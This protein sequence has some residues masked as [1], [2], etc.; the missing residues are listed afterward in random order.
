MLVSD[1]GN[2]FKQD[3]SNGFIR[4]AESKRVNI[5]S[6]LKET[7]FGNSKSSLASRLIHGS[8]WS[9][10]GAVVFRGST[11]ASSVVIARVLGKE[12]FGK[13]GIIQSTVNMFMVFACAG[14]GLTSTKF[15]SQ[16]RRKDPRTAGAVIGVS[17]IFSVIGGSICT[18]ALFVFSAPIAARFLAAP[19]LANILRIASPGLLFGAL[20]AVQIGSLM[21]FEAFR[22]IARISLIAGCASF[23]LVVGGVYTYG[24]RGAVAGTI[25]S[26]AIM[27]GCSQ[28][29]LRRLCRQ[30]GVA[31][32]LSE[33]RKQAAVVWRFTIPAALAAS[34]VGPV[35]WICSAALVNQRNGY[36]E[37]GLFNAANQW[38]AVLLFLPTILGQAALPSLSESFADRNDA[39]LSKLL[40][41]CVK[42]NLAFI[43]PVVV[44][45]SLFS[46]L[47]M[48][49]YGPAF[50][51]GWPVLVLSF[52]TAGILA[53]Q[54]PIGD[55][56]VASGMMWKGFGLN[57]IWAVLF[58]F[59]TLSAIRWGAAGLA[60]ARLFAYTLHSVGVI[61]I[62]KYIL[63][64]RSGP[65]PE[66]ATA[67]PQAN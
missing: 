55:L 10:V 60:G 54:S 19:D 58:I 38:F 44:L 52:V 9:L 16:F 45:G 49:L 17:L 67:G 66:F 30:E 29:V 11:L 41:I 40:M 37:M 33:C 24:L 48:R 32:L 56:I 1:A 42:A 14:V 21:G 62:A 61:W 22:S 65:V 12:E 18:L 64:S 15:V 34:L 25:L 3:F 23:P 43:A 28:L 27:C 53:L 6:D 31:I 7:I 2:E 46:P 59:A 57:A 13:F 20:N 36:S 35:N 39:R 63:T 8:F 47:I 26:L 4:S 5:R 51:S 50:A